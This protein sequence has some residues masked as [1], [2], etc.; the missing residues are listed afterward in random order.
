M[1]LLPGSRLGP[2]EILAALGAGGMGE[3]YKARDTRLDRTVAIKV[4]PDHLAADPQF[5]DRFDR[6]ARAISALEH[7]HICALYDVGK[8][9]GLSFLVM[10][11]LE[12][13]TLQDRLKKGSLPLDD[14]LKTAI[15]IAAALDA[16]HHAGI[17][18]RDLKPGNI[19]LTKGGARLL[20][21]GLAK[22]TPSVAAGGL[23]V[24]PTTPPNLTAQGT[25]LGTFQYMAPEQ[26]E[27]HEADARTDIFAFGAVLYEMLTGKRAFDGKSQASLIGAIMHAE[28]PPLQASQ[29]LAPP[30]LDR[31][32][33]TCLVKDPNERWQS[34]R[35][36]LHE[37]R[38]VVD[39]TALVEPRRASAAIAVLVGVLALALG[40]AAGWILRPAPH[41]AA[42]AAMELEIA[43]PEG[44]SF[45]PVSS[46][47]V[48][49]ISPDGREVALVATGKDGK[50]MLWLRPLASNAPRVLPGTDGASAPFWSLDG[51]WIGFEA[52]GKLKRI[53]QG[54]TQPQMIAETSVAH[55]T[56]NADGVTLFR[57]IG[58]PLYRKSAAGGAPA[59]VFE[60]DAARGEVDQGDPLFLPDGR[61]FLYF[62][63][64]REPGV[65]FAS[66]DGKTRRFLFAQSA[67]PAGYAADPAGGAG[68]ILYIAANQLVARHFDPVNGEV[69]GDP[70]L[71]ADSVPPGPSWSVSN[72]GVLIF[73]HLAFLSQTQFTWASRDGKP[74]G[75]V[76]ESGNLQ[77]P[78]LA[79]DGK[80]VSFARVD[81]GNAHVYLLD[82]AGNSTT[83]VGF[84]PGADT[85]PI[86]SADGRRLLYS[87]R[88]ANEMLI[89]ER[90]TSGL[91][92]EHILTRGRPALTPLP[93]DVS[94]DGRW[95]ALTEVGGGQSRLILLSL[96][97]GKTVPV[98]EAGV[99]S[100]GHF[101]PDGRWL[102]YTLSM[103]G[104]TDVFV[105]SL[106]AEAGGPAA[107]GK[108]QVSFSGGANPIWR[109]DG[110]EIFYL[111]LD[112]AVMDVPVESGDRD[113]R[114]GTPRQLFQARNAR[115]FDV[116]ADG[117]RF[118]LSQPISES[119]DT[120]LTVLVNWTAA[121][122]K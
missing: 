50:Q 61:H 22:S 112:G 45:G 120:P 95:L 16:A 121:M 29:P 42:Q 47:H 74:M 44:T 103:S 85:V 55:A 41:S 111:S 69:T 2:Y 58:R 117:Q 39:G 28:P 52:G 13:E 70:V 66:L 17:V 20:D 10:Q 32:V 4:L 26:L 77:R 27:G 89:V 68:W 3:V 11:Y 87:S 25:I 5:R 40:A 118:L 23:S 94:R 43:A 106:P 6:E 102:L 99:A 30:A 8:Q 84:E 67:S 59:P 15:E 78:R 98:T 107:A 53:D 119:S 80:T 113:F 104:R 72:T 100:D 109:A 65:V 51:Q 122:K 105:R 115:S 82:L 36:L 91:G 37:L 62:S 81:D 108:W 18:H 38:W 35:D 7:P 56:S 34:A 76:G 71:V 21:F 116:T 101:S 60:L 64:A 19:M 83:R 96:V 24:L 46:G 93:S 63:N 114:L 31:L 79:P 75:S 110:K 90:P 12:G 54:G 88:R 86:W 92:T 14:A 1:T 57:E 97:D 73:R 9:D 49:A 48:A 33:R